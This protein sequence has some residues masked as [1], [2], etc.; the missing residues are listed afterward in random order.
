MVAKFIGKDGSM[1]FKYGRIYNIN[2]YFQTS[3]GKTYIVIKCKSDDTLRPCAYD[4]VESLAK[5]WV[6]L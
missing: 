6:I 3:F 2:S 1:G 4:G 5:N